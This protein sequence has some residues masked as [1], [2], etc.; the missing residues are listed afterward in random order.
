MLFANDIIL[1]DE[2]RDG[3]NNKLEQWRHILESR[4]FRLSRSK[5]EYLK[6]RFSDEEAGGEKVTMY[7]VA[8]PRA[9]KFMYLGSTFE[10][11]CDS[12]KDI[13]SVWQS[14]VSC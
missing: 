3:L 10:G 7:S 9:E 1:I 13:G 4:E 14:A 6:Y 12:D 11:K 8:I 2:T 5:A